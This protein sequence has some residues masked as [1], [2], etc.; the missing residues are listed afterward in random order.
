M[1]SCP[2]ATVQRWQKR[3][4]L[5]FRGVFAGCQVTRDIPDLVRKGGFVIQPIERVTSLRLPNRDRTADGLSQ[6]LAPSRQ[7]SGRQ[8]GP[9]YADLKSTL[10][11]LA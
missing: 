10:Y 11:Q 3:T 5:L 2:D 6:S 1:G 7:L 8:I 4:D 9:W